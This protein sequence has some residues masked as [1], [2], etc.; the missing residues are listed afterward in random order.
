[1]PALI[2]LNQ[3][4]DRILFRDYL[5]REALRCLQRTCCAHELLPWSYLIPG[6]KLLITE[7]TLTTEKYP[8]TRKAKF[9]GGNVSVEVLGLRAQG[10]GATSYKVC[11]FVVCSCEP[12]LKLVSIEVLRGGRCLE[13]VTTSQYRSFPRDSYQDIALV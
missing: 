10:T 11:P 9:E 1:M 6:E 4:L 12:P 3:A 13:E 8:I 7:E 2:T 5:F